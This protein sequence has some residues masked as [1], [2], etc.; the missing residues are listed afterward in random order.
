MASNGSNNYMSLVGILIMSA[1]T[2]VKLILFALRKKISMNK[3][4]VA[5]MLR[6]RLS[7]SRREEPKLS[8]S[9][10][11]AYPEQNLKCI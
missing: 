9:P 3:E 10:S 5:E 1:M 7:M 4:E 11:N 8:V 2:H 6:T